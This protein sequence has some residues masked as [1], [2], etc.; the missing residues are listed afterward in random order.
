[1]RYGKR[2]AA[3]F[4]M[5]A[6]M[7]LAACHSV[8]ANLPAASGVL[9]SS[10]QTMDAVSS[11][12]FSLEL[13]GDLSQMF[14]SAVSGSISRDGQAEG[15]VTIG[16]TPYPFRLVAG[17]FYLQNPDKSW[18]TSPPAFDP[19]QLLDATNGVGSLLSG[20]T[21]AR[22]VDQVPVAGETADEINARVPTTLISQIADLASGQ[23]TLPAT[24]WIGANDSR[25]LQFRIS[26]RA[27]NS[28]APKT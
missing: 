16:G 28:Q 2:Q 27:P 3:W 20:A 19:T 11:T 8:P 9:E 22:T 12:T 14:I 23:A 5:P 13:S 24:L 21:G 18:V 17:T 7:A 15:S 25:L 26:F 10:A 4:L 6:L 1:M